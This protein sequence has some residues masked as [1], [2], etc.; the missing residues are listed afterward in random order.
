VVAAG[1]AGSIFPPD[2]GFTL[3]AQWFEL[4]MGFQE[5]TTAMSTLVRRAN[6]RNRS[7]LGKGSRLG[8][9]MTG[10]AVALLFAL[11]AGAQDAQ[12]PG[13]DDEQ[14]QAVQADPPSR[15]ARVSVLVGN[16][17]IEPASVNQF[18]AAEVNYPMTTGDRLYA[19]VGSVAEIQ[20][21]QLA[22]RL[23]QQ[24]DLS[25]TA[26][27]DTLAQFGVATGSVHL[28]SFGW[29]ANT[30]VEMDTPNVAVT[31]VQ[32]GDVR[33]DVD[34]NRDTTV[35][36]VDSGQV[37]V[38]GNGFEQILEAGQRVRLGGSD[39]VSA[40]W[41]DR[42]GGDGLD[43]FSMDRD[44]L[45][46]SSVASEGQ[47]VSPDT[48]GA[49][50]LSANGD[51]ETDS[52]EGPI[53]YPT[54]VAVDWQ[55]YSCGR[56]AWVAPWGWTW[57]GCESWGFAPFHYGRWE[58]RRD[59]WGWIPGPPVVRPIY[60]PALVA[61]VGGAG[62]TAWFPL[63]PHEP[64]L[65]WYHASPRYVN[66]VNVSNIYDRDTVQVR[67]IYNQRTE[68]SEYAPGGN[69]GYSN[70]QNATIGV[71]QDAFA[72]GRRV[73]PTVRV[74]TNQLVAAPVLPHPM[75]TPQRTM[76]VSAP[77]RAVPVQTARPTLTA[78][79]IDDHVHSI[80]RSE[81]MP[82]QPNTSREEE[83]VAR[84]PAAGEVR[85][86]RQPATQ[87]M[88]PNYPHETAPVVRQQSAEGMRPQSEPAAGAPM[89]PQRPLFN[90]TVPPAPRPSFE[91]QQRAIQSTDPGRPLSPQQMNN[92]RQNQPVG[93][94]QREAPHPP[95]APR[96][97][98]PPAPR[99]GPPPADRKH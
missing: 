52:D 65:P 46:E 70:R 26:M 19:D 86:E 17:S 93:Q 20:T 38:D 37:Q 89:Q 27:T 97:S 40:Q 92:L 34:P 54:N 25:V 61:F 98:P 44:N 18:S 82:V 77:A 50:D 83:P 13:D 11:P 85:S 36:T 90:R 84:Q 87:P 81:A 1:E 74:S 28:R 68:A 43:R 91:D 71:S 62:V 88:Q 99:S 94:Q 14:G 76:V 72:A 29:D 2:Y 41:L 42:S 5:G 78:A 7:T 48:I 96:A 30:T 51:W 80:G 63:G 21:G 58:R 60:S 8:V 79:P 35:V 66:R 10:V 3:Q 59:R 39:P 12:Q 73:G 32:P 16:V 53:W 67:T 33:V 49:E 45:Y 6:R 9:V 95:P 31:V 75:V 24:T 23:G 57:V 64:Y 56:W 47:Y 4:K 22:V 55:P 69:R 15:V